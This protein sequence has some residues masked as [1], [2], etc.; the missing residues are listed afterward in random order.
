[1]RFGILGPL[2]VR[3][4]DGAPVALG[5][6][7]PRA[8]LAQLLLH[9]NE[10]VSTD[11]LIDGD[12]GESPPAS[13]QNALQVH[14]HALRSA[15]GAD[16]ILTRAPG[17]LARRRRRAS[18]TSSVSSS[19]SPRAGPPTR[20]RSGAGTPSPTSHPSPSRR[21]R[22]RASTSGGSPRSR[23]GSTPTSRPARHA[24]S[25]PS[26]RLWSREHPHRERLRA[27]Q[28]LALYRAG[29]AGRRARRL[30]RRSQR[31]STSSGSS[32]LPS[33]AP[34]NSGSSARTRTSTR[35][36]RPRHA[37]W[38]A[39]PPRRRPSSAAASSSRRCRRSWSA[40]TRGS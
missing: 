6:P 27:Q 35:L 2:E 33:C 39:F 7:R 1:M 22:P 16:R 20:S 26:S 23:R 21:R 24:E 3:D 37:S 4:E 9:P 28:M 32:R 8:L 17:Y 12:L 31:P 40:L 36:L 19:S 25:P 10:A 14:V 38:T 13:A 11:R 5:G 15:L 29:T 34:S 30:P 18:S